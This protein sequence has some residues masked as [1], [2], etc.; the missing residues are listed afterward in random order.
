VV[1]EDG[2]SSADSATEHQ[3]ECRKKETEKT[4]GEQGPKVAPEEEDRQHN[5][6]RID[7]LLAG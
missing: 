2:D 3:E 7:C 5:P 6:L 4:E 1:E